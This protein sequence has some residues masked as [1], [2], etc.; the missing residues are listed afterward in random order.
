MRVKKTKKYLLHLPKELRCRIIR[1]TCK[2]RENLA[3]FL[4]IA[5]VKPSVCK[6]LCK[7]YDVANKQIEKEYRQDINF[8]TIMSFEK[9]CHTILDYL[10]DKTIIKLNRS[11]LNLGQYSIYSIMGAE[12]RF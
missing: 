2:V 12:L 11:N 7:E 4:E 5:K 9:I 1:Y 10:D 8:V 6:L 3:D